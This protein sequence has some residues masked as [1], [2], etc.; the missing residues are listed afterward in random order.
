MKAK[1]LCNRAMRFASTVRGMAERTLMF[2]TQWYN[3]FAGS[4][5]EAAKARLYEMG[6]NA[7]RPVITEISSPVSSKPTFSILNPTG[8]D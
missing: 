7:R 4:P 3:D 2:Q 6:N 1:G 5:F 8:E